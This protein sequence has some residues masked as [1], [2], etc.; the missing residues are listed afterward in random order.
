MTGTGTP[1]SVRRLLLHSRTQ[2]AVKAGLAAALSWVV[3]EL[4][5]GS[6]SGLDL[7]A[8]IYYA[9]LGAVVATYPTVASSLR[10]A[11]Y[12]VVAL[13]LGA[14]LGL[15]VQATFDPGP[16]SLALVVGAGVALGA[17]PGLGTQRSWV[18]IVALFV[19][20]IGGDHPFTYAMA[21]VA[22]TGLGTLCGVAVNIALPALR[23]T[24]GAD[25]L[26]RLR[27]LLSQQL[28][29]LADGLRQRPAPAR[30]DWERRMHDPEPEVDRTREAV[31]EVIDA[32]LG[33]P[34]A[35]FHTQET[36]RQREVAHALQR[37]AVFVEDLPEMLVQTYRED[38]DWGPLDPELAA[39]T[40]DALDRLADLV[41]AYDT[42][43]T[44]DDPRVE[45]VEEAVERLTYA[46]GRRRD[47]DADHVV[48]LGALVANLRRSAGAVK[49]EPEPKRG[50]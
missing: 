22:L 18:A 34:R 38:L 46:F 27:R 36:A 11:R 2:M 37:V 21:Y 30:E 14:A 17:L 10:T 26:R 9:P 7:G 6:L 40:A 44:F 35:R 49:P 25:A 8:Y 31:Q 20:I 48:V 5:T 43:L 39:V 47:L 19:L 4:I 13:A 12:S 15:L 33:N 3:A 42:D 50:G 24:Q 16:L 1:R 45:A 23:L 29:D 32:Q 41:E 28:R